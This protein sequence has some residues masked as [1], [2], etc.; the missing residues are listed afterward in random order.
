MKICA[1]IYARADMKVCPFFF[2]FNSRPRSGNSPAQALACDGLGPLWG[3]AGFYPR[4]TN[5]MLSRKQKLLLMCYMKSAVRAIAVDDW[6]EAFAVLDAARADE[7][8]TRTALDL[9]FCILEAYITASNE[10]VN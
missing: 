1:I 2:L 9:M 5:M 10:R 7:V 6:N 4:I 8:L 3:A